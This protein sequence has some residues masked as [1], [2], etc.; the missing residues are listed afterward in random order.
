MS[1]IVKSSPH[2]NTKLQRYLELA[3]NVRVLVAQVATEGWGSNLGF[4]TSWRTA[5]KFFPDGSCD[6]VSAT[7]VHRA[8]EQPAGILN[9]VAFC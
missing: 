8:D 1:S 5:L 2:R 9:P 3:D 4:C 6:T 7:P